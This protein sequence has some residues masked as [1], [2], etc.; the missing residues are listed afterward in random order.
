MQQFIDQFSTV[1]PEFIQSLFINADPWRVYNKYSALG[2]ENKSMLEIEHWV[3]SGVMMSVPMAKEAVIGWAIENTTG[4]GTWLDIS[5]IKCPAYLG[6]PTT[7]KIVPIGASVP[8]A[9]LL[10]NATLQKFP[11]GHIGML[12]KRL[13]F[14]PLADW[15]RNI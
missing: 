2:H 6:C 12:T 3:N 14:Q 1:P 7:D 4:K 10:E 9:G 11:C 13:C 8:L 15:L 5:D